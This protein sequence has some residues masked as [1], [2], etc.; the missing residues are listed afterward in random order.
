MVSSGWLGWNERDLREIC[1]GGGKVLKSC[2][3]AWL[4]LLGFVG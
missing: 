4:F 2:V 1:R 3:F